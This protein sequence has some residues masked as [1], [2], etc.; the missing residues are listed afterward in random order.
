MTK[1]ASARV[2]GI[3]VLGAIAL[4]V[5]G[6]I[7]FGSGR[8]FQ[9][10]TKYVL[11]FESPV[12]GLTIGAPVV[13]QGVKIGSVTDIRVLFNPETVS[14]QT[15]VY[16]ELLPESIAN[17]KDI[18][19]MKKAY[20][21]RSGSQELINTFVDR[22]LRA[23]L[24][25]Q[26]LVTGKL[27]VELDF[28]PGKPAY[29]AGLE[30]EF[31]EIP[32]IPSQLKELAKR[33][34]E[35]PIPEL[36]EKATHAVTSIDQLV[37]SPE[38]KESISALHLALQDV[39]ELVQSLNREVGPLFTSVQATL[40]DARKLVNNT[41]GQ[42]TRLGDSLVETSEAGETALVEAKNLLVKV[43]EEIIGERAA[44]RYQLVVALDE[45][46]QA[47]RAI[48]L[49][50]ESLEQQPDALLRGKLVSGGK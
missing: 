45:A 11:F 1:K 30:K 13:L 23:Q 36:V 21:L 2:I 48:R 32:T 19:K 35:I 20:Q 15:P 12:K 24:G 42:I 10:K 47:F 7:I 9:K 16:I 31:P 14:F 49:L 26:S 22:G 34:E 4:L 44:M 8:F 17:V 40:G 5:A 18:D 46:S 37:S 25:M 29:F 3:F 6:V 27:Q 38:V 50:A 28:H 33:L 39:R 41:D 43:D